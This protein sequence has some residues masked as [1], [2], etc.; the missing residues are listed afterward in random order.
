MVFVGSHDKKNP[1]YI[2]GCMAE[3]DAVEYSAMR[4]AERVAS[5]WDTPTPKITPIEE[6]RLLLRPED[7]W[8]VQTTLRMWQTFSL[9][10]RADKVRAFCKQSAESLDPNEKIA[11]DKRKRYL[12]FV[13]YRECLHPDGKK[14]IAQLALDGLFGKMQ[15]FNILYGKI[16]SG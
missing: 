1:H 8:D 10:D 14:E 2:G 15:A 5:K 9:E 12:L 7:K 11:E 3:I 13:M 4:E 16:K 6:E